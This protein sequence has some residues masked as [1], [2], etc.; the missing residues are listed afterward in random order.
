MLIT[1]G[2]TCILAPARAENHKGNTDEN[3][4]VKRFGHIDPLKSGHGRHQ[5]RRRKAERVFRHARESG[6][7]RPDAPEH[8]ENRSARAARRARGSAPGAE[9][10]P[11]C[12][13]A[14]ASPPDSGS[15]LSQRRAACGIHGRLHS[16]R[17]RAGD[18]NRRGN[19]SGDAG[20]SGQRRCPVPP[21]GAGA[22]ARVLPHPA[23][24][25]SGAECRAGGCRA[26][27]FLC[28]GN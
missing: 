3:S 13:G 7:P 23:R 24:K 12:R 27:V 22:L 2:G 9:R 25:V 15:D 5:G 18:R 20:H 19:R 26:A 1:P 6:N 8:T 28:V 16:G 11:L 21:A 17:R 4:L 14:G 10:A